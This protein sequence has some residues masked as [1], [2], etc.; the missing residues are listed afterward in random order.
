MRGRVGLHP[1]LT[2][3]VLIAGT[4]LAGVIGAI[5]A[6]PLMGAAQVFI[7]RILVPAIQG[8]ELAMEEQQESQPDHEA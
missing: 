6:V 7:K 2:I 4:D 5:L 1:L 8:A 3:V